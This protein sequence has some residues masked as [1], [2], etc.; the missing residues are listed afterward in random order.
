MFI[1]MTLLAAMA[2]VGLWLTWPHQGT[3]RFNQLRRA[4]R[5]GKTEPRGTHEVP[6]AAAGTPRLLEAAQPRADRQS[7][8]GT[9]V[10]PRWIRHPFQAFAEM[11]D[12]ADG[13]MS[14]EDVARQRQE[15]AFPVD[16][17]I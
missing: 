13:V 2:G 11:C 7:T 4:A 5:P 12:R 6:G 17:R 3:N 8:R 15:A 1:L 14:D 16:L 10:I 9:M